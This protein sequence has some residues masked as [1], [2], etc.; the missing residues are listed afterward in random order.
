MKK[1]LI[2]L[3]SIILAIALIF[4][5][6]F[7]A[8]EINKAAILEYIEGFD[9]VEYSDQLEPMLDEFGN[10][11]F[12]TDREFKVLH[13]TDVHLTGGVFFS[14]GDKK[15]LNAVAA[16]VKAEKP[17]LVVTTGDISFAVPW[18]GTLNNAYAHGYFA[19]LMEKLGVYWTVTFGN[20]DSEG[21]NYHGRS[22]VAKMY[23]DE[24]L[25]H[26]LF[27]SGP[28]DVFGECNHV[29]T[30][31]NSDGYV[32]KSL[33]MIDTNA[34]M[35]GD[36]L[37]ILW[38]YDNIHE[39]QIEWYRSVIEQYNEYNVRLYVEDN[40]EGSTVP[41]GIKT[42]K[43]LMFMHIP[44]F[45]VRE[46]YQEYVNNGRADTDDVKYLGGNDGETDEVVY[47]SEQPEEM[48]ETILELGST[49]ALFYGH[50]HLN[51]FRLEYKGVVLSYGYSIDYSAY[52]G[53]D[54]KG[55]QRGC[56]VIGID[57]DGTVNIVHENYYQDKYPSVYE[58]ESVDMSK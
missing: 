5:G 28:D 6:L 39:D 29:I 24:S 38:D 57:G 33:V 51:N 26:C 42:V 31:R 27:S 30:V 46:A 50:D 7:I 21:Y 47:C 32:T 2:I 18:T 4:L 15:A 20:H 44:L 40:G 43:S 22:A 1:I 19:A 13:L 41:D 55:Y 37:G 54:G 58:K 34:Y 52:F 35:E 49:E 16:M 3:G 23:E 48:F 8:N 56:A 12:T 14:G 25:E 11:Y 53:I 45:E 9:S 10:Y 36:P 17:D